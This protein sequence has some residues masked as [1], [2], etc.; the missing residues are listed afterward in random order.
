M[1]LLNFPQVTPLA[2]Q[3]VESVFDSLSDGH[4]SAGPVFRGVSEPLLWLNSF[5]LLCFSETLFSCFS[6][7]VFTQQAEQ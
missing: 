4:Q 2:A 3:G 7:M 1:R 5:A 6:T